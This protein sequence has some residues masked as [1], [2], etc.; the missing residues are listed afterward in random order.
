MVQSKT[1]ILKKC[2]KGDQ[3]WI[4]WCD[5]TAVAAKICSTRLHGIDGANTYDN[6]CVSNQQYTSMSETT[7]QQA[8]WNN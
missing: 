1:N 6:I 7:S 2:C 8:R 3:W 5:D 4:A